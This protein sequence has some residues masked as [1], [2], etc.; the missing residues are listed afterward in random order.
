MS[1]AALRRLGLVVAVSL[2]AA[3]STLLGTR[4]LI[5]SDDAVTTSF[6]DTD[7]KP[8]AID[9]L[10]FDDEQ[11]RPLLRAPRTPSG[12]LLLVPGVYAATVRSYCLHAGTHA[13]SAGDGYLFAPLKGAR[14]SI[15]RH[16]LAN[17]A[18]HPEI[19]QE[20]VQMLVWSV[21]A[22]T[23][24]D[25]YPPGVAA[26]A[27]KL[28]S[29]QEVL[30]L[31]GG[32]LGVLPQAV[33]DRA[34]AAAPPEVAGALRASNSLRE[35]VAR[36]NATFEE[37]ERVAVLPS[38]TVR[39]S[40]P[41]GRWSRHPGG[42]F[43]RYLPEGYRKTRI[44]VYVPG[45]APPTGRGRDSGANAP[46]A[47]AMLTA[48]EGPGA[49]SAFADFVYDPTGDVATPANTG[50]Q[51]LGLS[52]SGYTG[53]GGESGGGGSSDDYGP[54]DKESCKNGCQ[55]VFDKRQERCHQIK[56]PAKKRAC[57]QDAWNELGKCLADCD[58]EYPN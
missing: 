38:R 23:K 25:G 48:S 16:I 44:E 33:V 24:L 46:G 53:G 52:G 30:E 17:S 9:E 21:L 29:K 41:A 37:I 2:T 50:S 6:S 10:V 19:A 42:A 34:L 40:V 54:A 7:P 39:S 18:A 22:R 14:A 15:V 47:A 13:P 49:A 55:A 32:A 36:G 26:A 12:A 35:L 8:T 20:D 57:C 4:S 43:V 1:P 31:E 3:C 28:L 11:Y 45:D 5:G 51:R 58:K 27:G 56:D